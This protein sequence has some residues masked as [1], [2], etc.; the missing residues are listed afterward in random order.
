MIKNICWICGNPSETSEH[1][2]KKSDLIM[3]FG[4]GPYRSCNA[5]LYFKNDKMSELQGPNSTLVKYT[6]NLCFNCNNTLTQPFDKAYE[7]F[8]A[9]VMDNEI[10]VLKKRVIDFEAVYGIN[11]EEKQRNLFKYFVKCFGCR[12]DGI[13]RLVPFD[14]INLIRRETFDTALHVTF[15]VNEDMLL[16]KKEDQSIGTFPM[17]GEPE[18]HLI[19][20][21]GQYYCGHF[22]RWLKIIY[23]YN[24][25]PLEPVGVSWVANSKFI[26]LN[27]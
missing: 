9:W 23:W 22:Y 1:R 21:L 6:K 20:D 14:I 4:K 7:H 8:I 24:F 27:N 19:T 2:I 25:I 16:L 10:D 17:I 18:N 26:Y 15:Q 3:Q 11:W 12:I 13:G 5:L